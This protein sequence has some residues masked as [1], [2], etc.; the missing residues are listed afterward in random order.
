MLG[1]FIGDWDCDD[2]SA[3]AGDQCSEAFDAVFHLQGNDRLR[4]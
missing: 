1:E 4:G 2:L 3:R